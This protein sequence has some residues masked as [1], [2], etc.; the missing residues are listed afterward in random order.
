MVYYEYEEGLSTSTM[1]RQEIQLFEGDASTGVLDFALRPSNL[2]GQKLGCDTGDWKPV[3]SD[4]AQGP[5]LFSFPEFSEWVYNSPGSRAKK[6]L[7]ARV[8][9]CASC[10]WLNSSNVMAEFWDSI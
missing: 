6:G 2:R 8:F 10:P 7:Q 3:S 1:R 9:F 5:N 4:L